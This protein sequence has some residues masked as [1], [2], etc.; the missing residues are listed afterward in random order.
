M[1]K[2]EIHEYSF[3]SLDEHRSSLKK[4]RK[5]KLILLHQ[6]QL[7]KRQKMRL[8]SIFLQP[9]FLVFSLILLWVGLGCGCGCWWRIVNDESVPFFFALPWPAHMFGER[10][11]HPTIRPLSR[12]Q[13]KNVLPVFF[14]VWNK[15]KE[16]WYLYTLQFIMFSNPFPLLLS[17]LCLPHTRSRCRCRCLSF[18]RSFLWSVCLLLVASLVCKI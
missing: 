11:S 18:L 1:R 16:S 6:D 7:P 17:S 3:Q 13:T 12:F 14:L 2:R 4:K 8:V 9:L 10:P 15:Y 5:F